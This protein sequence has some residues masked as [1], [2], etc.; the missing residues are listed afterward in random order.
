MGE[1]ILGYIEYL[2]LTDGQDTDI[3]VAQAGEGIII[4]DRATHETKNIRWIKSKHG[5]QQGDP[6]GMTMYACGQ[7]KVLR[8]T[9]ECKNKLVSKWKR[10]HGHNTQ[11]GK[12]ADDWL[13]IAF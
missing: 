1:L 3:I 7:C 5:I 12:E 8:S 10:E 6:S 9:I 13:I 11:R 2:S 4:Q